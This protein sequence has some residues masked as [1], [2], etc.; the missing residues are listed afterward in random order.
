MPMLD[1]ATPYNVEPFAWLA[2]MLRRIA[3]GSR[4]SEIDARRNRAA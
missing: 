2:K 1:C 3:Y 4:S